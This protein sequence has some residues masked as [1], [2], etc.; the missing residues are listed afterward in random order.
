M[1]RALFSGLSGTVAFQSRLDVVGNNIANS[2][3][4]AYKQG[5]TIFQDALY[6]TMR[7]GRSGSDTGLGGMNPVQIG[8]GVTLGSVTVQQSQGSLERTGQPLD[9][10]IE[11]PGMFLL[12][13]GVG[14]FYSRDGSFALDNNNTMVHAGTGYLVQGWMAVGGEVTA[15]GPPDSLTFNISQL[16]PPVP[17]ANAAVIGNLDANSAEDAEVYTNVS[18]YDSLSELHQLTISFTK[19]ANVGE[20]D[21]EVSCGADSATTTVTFDSEGALNGDESVT[22][23]LNL[24]N[25]A[26][27]PQS[28]T[29]ALGQMTSLAQP[30]SVAVQSQDGRPASSLVSVELTDQGYVEG[31]Y[32]DGRSET[33]AQ[34]ALASFANPGGLRRLGSNLFAEA[35]AAGIPAVGGANTGGRGHVV[36]QALEMSNVDLTK[37]FVDMIITQKGFQASTRV[38]ATATEMLDEVVRLIRS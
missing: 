3:T 32:S 19:T 7:G 24:T 13:G 27:T 23:D 35:P 34:V 4:V 17:T 21:V 26:I 29:M 14:T 11:G 9:G 1:N 6:E 20:W 16:T 22:L 25:G 8:S 28:V 2:N 15:T 5:R 30:L 31:Q 38:I 36:G 10:A 33:L 18:V 12:S 37:A